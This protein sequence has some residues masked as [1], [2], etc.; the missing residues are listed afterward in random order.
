[1][2]FKVIHY[3]MNENLTVVEVKKEGLPENVSKDQIYFWL[4]I[5]TDTKRVERLDFQEMKEE[6]VNGKMMNVRIFS[7][8]DLRFDDFF[9]RCVIHRNGQILMNESKKVLP[10]D[11]LQ[12]VTEYLK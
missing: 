8:G 9:A 5:S 11:V 7:Q 6:A 3:F 2:E 10:E 1:M 12:L 4:S